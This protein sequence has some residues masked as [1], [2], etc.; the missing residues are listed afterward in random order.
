MWTAFCST[1]TELTWCFNK[2]TSS[3]LHIV[4]QDCN[5]PFAVTNFDNPHLWHLLRD[6]QIFSLYLLQ[7]NV[8]CWYSRNVLRLMQYSWCTVLRWHCLAFNFDWHVRLTP[9]CSSHSMPDLTSH[10]HLWISFILWILCGASH[11]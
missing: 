5:A 4:Q 8:S 7:L 10:I 6:S 9:L 1:T 2:V 3:C 11:D